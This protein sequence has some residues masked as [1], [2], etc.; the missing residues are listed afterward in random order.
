MTQNLKRPLESHY[1]SNGENHLLFPHLQS[2]S[3]TIC[4]WKMSQSGQCRA[5]WKSRERIMEIDRGCDSSGPE[6]DVWRDYSLS[7]WASGVI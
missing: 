6:A 7:G 5:D 3:E 1:S 2:S 4:I